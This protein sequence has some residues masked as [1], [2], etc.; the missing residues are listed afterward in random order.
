VTI[1][2]LELCVLAE[3]REIGRFVIESFLEGRTASDPMPSTGR[4]T[5]GAT[6]SQLP[7]VHVVMA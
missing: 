3:Q 6:F 4:V 1:R 5:V 2:A 7:L